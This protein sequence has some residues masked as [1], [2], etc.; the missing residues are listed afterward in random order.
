MS[1]QMSLVTLTLLVLVAVGT[2]QDTGSMMVV[3]E[4]NMVTVSASNP[5]V[6]PSLTPTPQPDGAGNEPQGGGEGEIVL[7]IPEWAI[8]FIAVGGVFI[9]VAAIAVCGMCVGVITKSR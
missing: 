7:L 9:C 1:L 2:G 6:T 5:P 4:E 8:A 3:I